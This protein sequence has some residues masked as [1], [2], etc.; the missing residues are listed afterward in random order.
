MKAVAFALKS[1][2]GMFNTSDAKGTD[3]G[4]GFGSSNSVKAQKSWSLS[5]K[6]SLDPLLLILQDPAGGAVLIFVSKWRSKL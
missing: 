2:A 5:S 3:Y 4:S 1:T 6:G